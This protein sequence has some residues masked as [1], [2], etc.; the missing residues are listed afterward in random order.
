M[1]TIVLLSG[2]SE[3]YFEPGSHYKAAFFY[4]ADHFQM[5]SCDI[6]GNRTKW[7]CL[8][9]VLSNTEYLDPLKKKHFVFNDLDHH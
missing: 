1:Q 7:I 5:T 4:M 6:T 9:C 2:D 3:S 8:L